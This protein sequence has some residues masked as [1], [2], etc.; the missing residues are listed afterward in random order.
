ML[1]RYLSSKPE[2][3]ERL[4]GLGSFNPNTDAVTTGKEA[5]KAGEKDLEELAWRWQQAWETSKKAEE[6]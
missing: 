2:M 5:A 1:E 6:R 3:T 4:A